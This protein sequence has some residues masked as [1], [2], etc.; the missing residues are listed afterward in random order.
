VLAVPGLA[1]GHEL[2]GLQLPAA[3]RRA[4]AAPK[5]VAVCVDARAA[6][7]WRSLAGDLAA[8]LWRLLGSHP[9]GLRSGLLTLLMC[10]ASELQRTMDEVLELPPL[11][12]ELEL[13]FEAHAAEME[14]YI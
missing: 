4:C 7:D 9:P 12:E 1:A 6:E 13:Q 11:P 14:V 10:E 2:R 8:E 3:P 5:A